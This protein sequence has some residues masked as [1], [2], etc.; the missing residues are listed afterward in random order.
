MKEAIDSSHLACYNILHVMQTIN[1]VIKSYLSV[2]TK[3][4]TIV[5]TEKKTYSKKVQKLKKKFAFGRD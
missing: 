2:K 1:S 4:Q 5:I 3:A